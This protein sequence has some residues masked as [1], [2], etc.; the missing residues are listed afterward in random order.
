MNRVPAIACRILA[1]LPRS[2]SEVT[3]QAVN[4]QQQGHNNESRNNDGSVN[5]N[6]DSLD[7]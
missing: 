6:A 2:L 3:M 5:F 1:E 4:A 7:N